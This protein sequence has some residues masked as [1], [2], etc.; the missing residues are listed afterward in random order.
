MSEEEVK[1][2]IK[3]INDQGE[4]RELVHFTRPKT[5]VDEA[6]FFFSRFNER[7]EP[8]LTPQSKKLIVAF[9]DK[10]ME[11]FPIIIRRFEFDVDKMI[12]NGQVAF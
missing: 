6:V 10:I 12:V 1:Q 11:N 4:M 7:G 5:Q 2:N 9:G 8:L 3:L